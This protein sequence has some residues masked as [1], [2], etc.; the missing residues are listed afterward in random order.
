MQSVSRDDWIF[1]R[2]S[3]NG[4]G[5]GFSKKW[6]MNAIPQIKKTPFN[7]DPKE[8]HT[9]IS[10]FRDMIHN[11][12][13]SYAHRHALL[14]QLLSTEVRS[15]KAEY[16]DNPSTYYD[17]LEELKK[18]YGQQTTTGCSKPSDGT[19]ETPINPR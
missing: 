8:W 15:Y 10:S 7:V 12:V 14:K 3:T 5:S 9:F 18:C 13:P 19:Y 1:R 16:F 4:S 6:L 17:A 2:F 11:V